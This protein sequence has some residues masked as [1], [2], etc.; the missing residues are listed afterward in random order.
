VLCHNRDKAGIDKELAD[1][2]HHII[3]QFLE[4]TKNGLAAPAE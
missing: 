4:P 3:E 2:S 1:V